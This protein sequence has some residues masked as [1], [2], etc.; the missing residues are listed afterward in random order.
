MGCV[1]DGFLES[2]KLRRE[3][4][5]HVCV[6]RIVDHIRH[7]EGIGDEVVQLPFDGVDRAQ[8]ERIAWELLANP[9]IQTVK[10][11][12]LNEQSV[13]PLKK[14]EVESTVLKSVAAK[15]AP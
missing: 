14:D 7:F 2:G 4:G 5:P 8:A 6:A 10:V 15:M 13:S 12:T 3:V 11:Q 1:P 9:V